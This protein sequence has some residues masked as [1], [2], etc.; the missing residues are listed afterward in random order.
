MSLAVEVGRV[1]ELFDG[2]LAF[3]VQLLLQPADGPAVPG[4]LAA[5][6]GVF[7]GNINQA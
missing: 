7:L 5:R 2:V 1:F 3:G 6:P 4:V